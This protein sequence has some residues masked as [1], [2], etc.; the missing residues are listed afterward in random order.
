MVKVS[1]GGTG[2]IY[3]SDLSSETSW[4]SL[5]LTGETLGGKELSAGVRVFEGIDKYNATEISLGDIARTPYRAQRST[6]P[7]MTLRAR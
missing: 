3:L 5:D 4:G 6:M 1:S 2:Y 7:P